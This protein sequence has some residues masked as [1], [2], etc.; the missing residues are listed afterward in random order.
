M[1]FIRRI[2][3]F[4]WWLQWLKNG[5]PYRQYSGYNCGCCG[6]WIEKEFK[7]PLYR[8]YG[9]WADTWGLCPKCAGIEFTL[10]GCANK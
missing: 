10:K 8:S 3:Q 9:S 7:V 2:Q 5:T 1:K 4:F 6:I